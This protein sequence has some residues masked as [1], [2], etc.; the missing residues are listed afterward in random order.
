MV[1]L[2]HYNDLTKRQQVNL[3]TARLN[4][5]LRSDVE[6]LA[7]S[8]LQ[9]AMSLAHSYDQRSTANK[10]EK[11][12][13]TARPAVSA[14]NQAAQTATP[15]TPATSSAPPEA[16]SHRFRRLIPEELSAKR[17]KEECYYCTDKYVPGHKCGGKGVFLL[18]LDDGVELE[19]L[20]EEL[21]IS[22]HA[23]TGIDVADTM[24]LKVSIAGQ[25]L[26]ALVNTG[27]T[28]TF[29][30]DHVARRTRVTAHAAPW[31]V[32]VSSQRRPR[33]Q[34]RRVPGDTGHHRC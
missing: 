11:P 21:G 34:C 13:T 9:T 23:L 31:A 16:D 7:P 5:P 28:H 15:A 32:G 33:Y 19:D 8:N 6:L 25:Q 2:C 27:S 3:F 30:N 17:A 4:Q 29:V 20:A 24:K 10:A 22:L 1:Y 18:E 14:M 26:T 12:A